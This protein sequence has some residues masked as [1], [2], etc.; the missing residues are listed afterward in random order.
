MWRLVNKFV[1]IGSAEDQRIERFQ[2]ALT[3]VG[4]PAAHFVDYPDLIKGHITLGDIL[5]RGDILRIESPGK[6]AETEQLLL[7][8]GKHDVEPHFERSPSTRQ[9]EGF[10]YA[11]RQWYLGLCAVLDQIDS[12]RASAPPHHIMNGTDAIRT[13]FDKSATQKILQASGISIPFF[14]PP[15]HNYEQLR[16]QMTTLGIHR[17]FIKLAHGSS[18]SGA[19]AYETNGR[20]EKATTTIEHDNQWRLFNSLRV[21]TL[22]DSATIRPLIDTL[23]RHRVHVEQWIPKGS[24]DQQRFDVRVLVI[25]GQAQHSVVRLSNS[26]FTNL[27]LGNNRK[28]I[29]RLIDQ[30][31]LTQWKAV[32]RTCQQAAACFPDAFYAGIDLLFTPN[33]N[34]HFI[35][36]LNAFGDLLFHVYRDGMDTYEMQIRH[37]ISQY[38]N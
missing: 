17:V 20:Q 14:F 1:I 32:E 3:R 36:E 2:A 28:P 37:F 8:L 19:I 31:S 21:R 5:E 24:L 18:A 16:T 34:R 4:L 25:A 12:Q 10:I 33:L 35:L 26:P 29:E 15:I 9:P 38:T 11:S 27:H 6:S 30:T 22:H 23:C 13:M 7:Q